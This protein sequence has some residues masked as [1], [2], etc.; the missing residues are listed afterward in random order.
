MTE[1]SIKSTA[2]PPSPSPNPFTPAQWQLL[3]AIADTIIAPVESNTIISDHDAHTFAFIKRQLQGYADSNTVIS[4][5]EESASRVPGFEGALL[6]FLG[7][8]VAISARN[9]LATFLSILK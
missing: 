9:D 1:Q 7:V 8:H 5:L 4:Y 2:L 6:R 3:L